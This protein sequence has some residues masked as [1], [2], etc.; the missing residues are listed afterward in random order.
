MHVRN[1]LSQEL[2]VAVIGSACE[3]SFF[4]EAI[5]RVFQKMITAAFSLEDVTID[6][7]SNPDHDNLT[8][9]DANVVHYIA[10]YVG[11]NHHIPTKL[12]CVEGLLGDD[13][14]SPSAD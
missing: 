8:Y 13:N 7:R 4:Q 6:V 14:N 12:N 9:E 1:F 11:R 5:D 3:P 10:G 2:N